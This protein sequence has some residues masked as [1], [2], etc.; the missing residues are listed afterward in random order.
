MFKILS[1]IS[2]IFVLVGCGDTTQTS[3]NKVSGSWSVT[4][5]PVND[6]AEGNPGITLPAITLA[7]IGNHI[8][9]ESS[10][11]RGEGIIYG[12][13]VDLSFYQTGE[14]G[15]AE[16]V[17]TLNLRLN[18][19]S[20]MTGSGKTYSQITAK[21]VI[22]KNTYEYVATAE[23]DLFA[24]EARRVEPGEIDLQESSDVKDVACNLVGSISSFIIG[25]GSNNAFRPMGGCWLNEQG[26][27]YYIFGQTGPGSLAPI[28]TQTM[29]YPI[30]EKAVCK[31]RTYHFDM[32]IGNQ[33]KS[34]DKLMDN[35]G[36]FGGLANALGFSEV[37]ALLILV[38]D[39]YN[40]FGGFAFS[41]AISTKSGNTS[42]YV[43]L[44][45][46][47]SHTEVVNHPLVSA[48][49]KLVP[50]GS[51]EV[52]V[53]QQISDSFVL[54][55]NFTPVPYSTYCNTPLVIAYLFGTHEVSYK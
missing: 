35:L 53:G 8:S 29:Y 18:D 54:R 17:L 13:N 41:Y 15:E 50:G 20:N 21:D 27:G 52:F 4:L 45:S 42:L 22:N 3:A 14:N 7:Q 10:I 26:G 48:V 46:N 2:L 34:I 32:S 40:K 1:M 24:V 31:S 6:D 19:I 12:N 16:K 43:N 49:V 5:R 23:T 11:F 28:W 47:W 33:V 36:G 38:Q 9:G 44:T 37:D 55:R 51:K 39:F 30:E 25:I